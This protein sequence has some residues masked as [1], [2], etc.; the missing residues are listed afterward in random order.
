MCL[1]SK[2]LFLALLAA[3][4]LSFSATVMADPITIFS[5][6]VAADGSLL[7]GGSTDPHYTII[8]S[9]LGST[10]VVVPTLLPA[11]W[12]NIVG[13]QWLTISTN[14]NAGVPVGDFIYR[15]T[16]D[17]T[18]FDPTTAILAGTLAADNSVKVLLNGKETGIF[19]PDFTKSLSFSITKGFVS[20]INTL[21]FLVDNGSGPAGLTVKIQGIAAAGAVI[22]DTPE[23][24]TLVLFGTGLAAL[25]FK[26]R[27][28]N[29]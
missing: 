23:P 3:C 12:T 17:L 24:A 22:S 13:A 8:S 16:F 10:S 2:T 21:D 27:R 18:G 20:G 29:T 19:F 6:G 11:P 7:P 9:P 28:K 1:T 15:T 14:A 25:A 5:T 26:R 4:C